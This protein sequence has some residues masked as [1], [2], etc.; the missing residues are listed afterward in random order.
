MPLG[1]G[2]PEIGQHFREQHQV[3]HAPQC[4]GQNVLFNDHVL[5]HDTDNEEHEHL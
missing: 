1:Q 3:G 2:V 5:Q 4:V